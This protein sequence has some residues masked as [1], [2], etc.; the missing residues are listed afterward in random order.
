MRF[1]T[2]GVRILVGSVFN[3]GVCNLFSEEMQKFLKETIYLEQAITLLKAKTRL[4]TIME[5][6]KFS[7]NEIYQIAQ[8]NNLQVNDL[9]SAGG[10]I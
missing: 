4:N 8:E 3:R 1:D 6:T 7:K 5:V 9:E 2:F 10:D